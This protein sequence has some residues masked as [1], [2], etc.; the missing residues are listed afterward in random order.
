MD[1]LAGAEEAFLTSSLRGL[2][3]LVRVGAAVVGRG[4]PGA[5]TR[6]LAAAYTALVAQECGSSL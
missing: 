5:L 2:A 1:D 4:V 6:Q 3:P